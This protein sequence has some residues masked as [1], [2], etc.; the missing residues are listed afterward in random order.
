[1]HDYFASSVFAGVLLTLAAYFLGDA[2]RRKTG[3]S[4]LNPILTGSAMVI[5]FLS[6]F[7]IDYAAYSQS[8]RIISFFLTPATVCLAVPLYEQFALLKKHKAAILAG[9]V[10]GVITSL[11][12]VLALS[13]L[14]GLSHQ[15]YV[16]L[17]PKSITNAIGM[18]VSEQLGGYP[19]I[20]VP[21]ILITGTLGSVIAEPVLRLLHITEPVARGVAIGTSSHAIGTTKA[22][23][24]GRIEGAMSSLSIVVSGIL[25][26][27]GAYIFSFFL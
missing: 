7:R 20:T 26:V 19:S 21:V 1:M 16:T 4:L 9:I 2:I 18:V 13:F 5:V 11:V 27:F 10:S 14:F 6:V 23:E 22:M 24:L 3:I 12:C 25:T 17:L 15:D 8:S